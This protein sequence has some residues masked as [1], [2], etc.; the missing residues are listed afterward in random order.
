MFKLYKR[1]ELVSVCSTFS[2]AQVMAKR[3]ANPTYRSTFTIQAP[4]GAY[5]RA[6][7][8]QGARAKWQRIKAGRTRRVG[9]IMGREPTVARILI[10]SM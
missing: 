1:D 5:Y 2:S 6:R 9:R 4:R 7:L 10:K 3:H 8:V